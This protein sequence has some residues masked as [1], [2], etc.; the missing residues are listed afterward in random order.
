VTEQA[1]MVHP[2]PSAAALRIYERGY[3]YLFYFQPNAAE[4][5]G[6]TRVDMMN[7]LVASGDT[8]ETAAVVYADDFFT[9]SIAAGLLGEVVEIPGRR[10]PA[11]AGHADGRLS[12]HGHLQQPGF[13][14]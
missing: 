1:G 13:P 5:I 12:T 14:A 10:H 6:S 3:E 8:P 7:D 11:D 9:N 4:F 2:I